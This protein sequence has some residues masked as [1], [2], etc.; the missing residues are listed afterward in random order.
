MGH[1]L[2]RVVGK[3]GVSRPIKLLL[4]ENQKLTSITRGV[5]KQEAVLVLTVPTFT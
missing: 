1:L 2:G 4:L 3:S 5:L